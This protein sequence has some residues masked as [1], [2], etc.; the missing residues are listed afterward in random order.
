MC[1]NRMSDCAHAHTHTERNPTQPNPQSSNP[2]TNDDTTPYEK[3]RRRTPELLVTAREAKAS[4]SVGWMPIMSSK[5]AFFAPICWG[6]WCCVC[7]GGGGCGGSGREVMRGCDLK[8]GGGRGGGWVID[9]SDEYASP[10]PKTHAV[11]SLPP[12]TP[13]PSQAAASLPPPSHA[14]VSSLTTC[15][16]RE[17]EALGDLPCVGADEVEAH[18]LHPL[19]CLGWFWGRRCGWVCTQCAKAPERRRAI[20][21]INGQHKTPTAIT[22]PH[23]VLEADEL[24]EAHGGEVVHHVLPHVLRHSLVVGWGR[25][26]CWVI[27]WRGGGLFGDVVVVV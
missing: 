8:G 26:C 13:S 14:A 9:Q 7:W 25:E 15:L 4:A 10:K 3:R 24:G 2:W 12:H 21:Q 6:R 16:E 11:A 5:S 17:G 27:E 19:C 18:H 1:Q 23:L 20:R 22:A